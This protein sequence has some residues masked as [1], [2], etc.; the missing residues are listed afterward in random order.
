MD[1]EKTSR[2]G[3]STFLYMLANTTPSSSDKDMALSERDWVL[4]LAVVSRTPTIPFENW[5]R[6][7]THDRS[8]LLCLFND[9]SCS[10][11][12]LD[13]LPVF[14]AAARRCRCSTEGHGNTWSTEWFTSA[15]P[16]QPAKAYHLRP[17]KLVSPC[18]VL[19]RGQIL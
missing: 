14:S 12:R 10:K 1:E 15:I 13:C 17:R 19:S 6:W 11:R 2:A 9:I 7:C 4:Q 18:T 8:W 3:M 16:Q 5:T